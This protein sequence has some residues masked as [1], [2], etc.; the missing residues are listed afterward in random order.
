MREKTKQ[1]G[2]KE[3]GAP[4]RQEWK[5]EGGSPKKMTL[6]GKDGMK[7]RNGSSRGG[8]GTLG[9]TSGDGGK[10]M[11]RRT[12]EIGMRDTL[13]TG[14]AGATLETGK[15]AAPA[16]ATLETGKEAA[17]RGCPRNRARSTSSS[18]S[19]PR[20][21]AR[22]SSSSRSNPSNRGSRS[23][24]K[25][26]T[27]VWQKRELGKIKEEEASASTGPAPLA[28][29]EKLGIVMVDFHNTLEVND[30][31]PEENQQAIWSLLKKGYE[32][33]VCSYAG[34]KRALEV[35]DTMVG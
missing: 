9:R 31:I 27:L 6:P 22:S 7:N 14:P 33:V 13:H 24:S 2:K 30:V 32:V 3:L 5:K 26:P 25:K 18:R 20:N 4:P 21:R 17:S 11:R 1:G 23:Q 19:N 29:G 35:N 34:R 15:E 28:K 16:G 12:L 10:R 8:G